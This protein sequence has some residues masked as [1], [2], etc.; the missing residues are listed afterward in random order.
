MSSVMIVGG[1]TVAADGSTQTLASTEIFD[2]MAGIVTAGPSLITARSGHSATTALDGRVVVIGG[3]NPALAANG[4]AAELA[5][6]EIFDP[7]A[8]TPA[9]T[10][11]ASQLATARTGHLAF[12]LPNNA[13]VLIVGGTAAGAQLSSVELYTPWTDAFQATGSMAA[14]R[15]SA[16]GTSMMYHTGTGI[17]G[18]LLVVAGQNASG[19]LASGE[20]YGFATV[21]TDKSDYAPGTTVTITGSGW[22]PGETVNLTFRELPNIDTPGPYTAV[23]DGN[24]N[25]LDTEFAPDVL[26]VNVR[27]YLTAVGSQS[28]LQAQN[29]FT[30]A[31]LSFVTTAFVA[32]LNTCSP[33][34]QIEHSSTASVP[35]TLSSSSSGGKFYSDSTCS[36]QITTITTS[37]STPSSAT[38]Y[39]QDSASGSPTITITDTVAPNGDSA[40][41]T[42]TIGGTQSIT[43]LTLAAPSPGSVDFQ[44]STTV[45]LTATLKAGSNALNKEKVEF[46]VDGALVGNPSTGNNNTGVATLTYDPSSLSIGNHTVQAIFEG[47]NGSTKYSASTSA[48]QTLTVNKRTTTTLVSSCTPASVNVG[49]ATNCTATVTDNDTGTAIGPTGS[50]SF[51]TSGSGTFGPCTLGTA[52]G[53]SASCSFSYTPT[54]FGTGTH[55]ITG[56]YGGDATHLT[57]TSP[58]FNLT[59]INPATTTTVS[60]SANPSKYGDSVTFTATVSPNSGSTTPTG[61]VA[62]IIDGGT[63]VAG[64]AGTCPLTAPANSLCATYSTST[65]TVNGGSPHSVQANYTHT[66]NFADSSGTLSGG[67]TVN[68]K[69]V[70]ATLT[71]DDKVYDG[72]AT[73][74]NAKLHCTL[75][76][77]SAVGTDDVGCTAS[78]G[79]FNSSQVAT[80]N[81]VTATVALSGTTAGNY[82]LTG[83]PWP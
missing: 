20:F 9:F 29:T 14:A 26:D 68:P 15:A 47:D 43:T 42:E 23:A 78:G 39:Y 40:T 72:N 82:S 25:I 61:T 53:N 12:L 27:F 57:S 18:L 22:K 13:N 34:I 4:A 48:L 62:F 28:G 10:Q 76:A 60:S 73:E 65:L 33:M 55:T 83:P 32:P 37:A 19:T 50:V 45:T 7:S 2:P 56:S 1:T 31:R 59:V 51:T 80:A 70:T 54:A 74:P 3:T 46:F 36:T 44:S 67:Q 81:S 79:A 64:T 35:V 8:T 17:D 11:S 52:T 6:A 63:P 30:D 38:L 77:G 58:G 49:S 69:P 75:P 21:K 16:A 5:S 71:A 66:G 24:G 41:Q